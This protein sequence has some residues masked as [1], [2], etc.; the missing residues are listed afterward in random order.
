VIF[1]LKDGNEAW[2]HVQHWGVDQ[3]RVAT[4]F[5]VALL[6]AP[7]IVAFEIAEMLSQE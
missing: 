6:P 3:V 5:R 1:Y 4:G 2:G 7:A